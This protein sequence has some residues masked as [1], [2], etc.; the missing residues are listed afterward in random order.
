MRSEIIEPVAS[1]LD[2]PTSVRVTG[3]RA[4]VLAAVRAA[5]Q[6]LTVTDVARR[7][8]LH[9]NTARFHLG[10][11]EAD[12]L[13]ERST[14]K[15]AGPGRPHILYTA[16]DTRPGPRSYRLLAQMLTGLVAT[17][18]E[19]QASAEEVGRQWGAH[20]VERAAPSQRISVADA[21][22]RLTA[23]LDAIGFQPEVHP[24]KGRRGN[25][26]WLHHCPFREVAEEHTDV[27]CAIHLGL[28]QGALDEVRAPVEVVSLE[29][30]VS[31]D[32][33]VARLRTVVAHKT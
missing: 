31:P 29:P 24:A 9:V 22:G 21:M 2:S 3:R 4:K 8:G 11:L 32:N 33:C 25:A 5:A 6:P 16:R 18:P 7:S 17:L 15:R 28:M 19:A 20:L 23:V 12:G 26:V 1:L 27:V 10:R 14:E 13:V 30:F